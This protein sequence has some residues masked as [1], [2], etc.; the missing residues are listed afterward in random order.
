MAAGGFSSSG[1]RGDAD[2]RFLSAELTRP[3]S[4]KLHLGVAVTPMVINQPADWTGI[5]HEDVD[6]LALSVLARWHFDRRLLG[7]RPWADIRTGPSWSELDVPY[8][9]SRFNFLTD[10]GIGLTVLERPSYAI[11]LGYRLMHISNAGTAEKN[12]GWTFQSLSFSVHAR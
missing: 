7:M 4:D 9:T 8:E 5:P 2:I 11:N 12:P 1:A 3:R 6:G 10:A